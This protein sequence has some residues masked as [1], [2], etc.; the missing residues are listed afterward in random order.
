MVRQPVFSESGRKVSFRA[1]GEN[2]GIVDTMKPVQG[3]QRYR[4]AMSTAGEQGLLGRALLSGGRL[5]CSP[6]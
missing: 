4:E 1:A 2:G 5:V 3:K 6:R